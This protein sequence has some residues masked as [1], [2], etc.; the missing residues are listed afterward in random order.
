LQCP[1]FVAPALHPLLHPRP[2]KA[3][4]FSGV[5]TVLHLQPPGTHSGSRSHVQCSTFDVRVHFDFLL[6]FTHRY[7]SNLIMTTNVPTK[8][9]KAACLTLAAHP[10]QLLLLKP[11]HSLTT[12]QEAQKKLAT[13]THARFGEGIYLLHTHLPPQQLHDEFAALLQEGDSLCVI[14]ATT[15]C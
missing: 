8:A 14:S 6:G 12:C 15:P 4:M 3:P 9:N 7:Q 1:H 11:R 10:A 2:S 5:V 13:F